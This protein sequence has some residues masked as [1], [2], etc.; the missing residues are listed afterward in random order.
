MV[1]IKDGQCFNADIL[2][3][4]VPYQCNRAVQYVI[5]GTCDTPNCIG[6]CNFI[7]HNIVGDIHTQ[8]CEQERVRIACWWGWIRNGLTRQ[9]LDHGHGALGRIVIGARDFP[10]GINLGNCA[11]SGIVDRFSAYVLIRMI[12]VESWGGI[13]R[14]KLPNQVLNYILG[15]SGAI[16]VGAGD[17]LL[18]V[19]GGNHLSSIV[20][21]DICAY[22]FATGAK[23]G[24]RIYT[25]VLPSQILHLGG[26]FIIGVVIDACDYPICIGGGNFVTMTVIGVINNNV[27][28]TA[29]IFVILRKRWVIIE[30]ANDFNEPV[31]AIINIFCNNIVACCAGFQP[32]QIVVG[33]GAR[34]VV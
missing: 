17:D 3:R 8:I 34:Q 5:I 1:C 28:Y 7:S 18:R 30:V 26:N 19:N 25:D 22:I 16:I 27:V 10:V 29:G 33:R 13:D 15:S 12:F 14:D 31:S 32:A 20:I 6:E 9:I 23:C 24:R 2:P 11:A 4:Q 21:D